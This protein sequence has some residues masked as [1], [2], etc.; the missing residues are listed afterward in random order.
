MSGLTDD[1]LI[2]SMT[3]TVDGERY[4]ADYGVGKFGPH[5]GFVGGETHTN[6]QVMFQ[7]LSPI[8]T[9]P[10]EGEFHPDD[11][12]R[13]ARYSGGDGPWDSINGRYTGNV[14]MEKR[15]I[16]LIFNFTAKHRDGRLKVVTAVMNY[17]VRQSI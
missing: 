5:D 2:G 12:H 4:T 11:F 13:G 8:E 10:I 1:D 17:R 9:G 7:F 14:D 6:K 16:T 15:E 3:F